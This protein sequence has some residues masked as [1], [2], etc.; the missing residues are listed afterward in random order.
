MEK[1]YVYTRKLNIR[2]SDLNELSIKH[3]TGTSTNVNRSSLFVFG[4]SRSNLPPSHG[5]QRLI[6]SSGLSLA[7]FVVLFEKPIPLRVSRRPPSLS[8]R[9]R[10]QGHRDTQRSDGRRCVT[11]VGVRPKGVSFFRW[12]RSR[13]GVA[14]FFLEEEN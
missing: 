4:L 13:M 5:N 11:E 6:L 1:I 10:H 8:K 3:R 14:P 9:S 2:L 7:K 12:R